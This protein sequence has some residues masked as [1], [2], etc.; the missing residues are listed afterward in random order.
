MSLAP[1]ILQAGRGAFVA[2]KNGQDF[3]VGEAKKKWV[4][5]SG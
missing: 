2:L 4:N 3:V 1:A 5:Y